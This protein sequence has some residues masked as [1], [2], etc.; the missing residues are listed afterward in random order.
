[1]ADTNWPAIYLHHYDRGLEALEWL[2]RVFNFH[3]TIRMPQGVGT[4]E[5]STVPRAD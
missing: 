1:M 4:T 5:S 3:E 2:S